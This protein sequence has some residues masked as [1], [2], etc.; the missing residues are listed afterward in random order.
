MRYWL[1][2]LKE[3][4]GRHRFRE[5]LVRAGASTSEI[6]MWLDLQTHATV[7][8]KVRANANAIH[9]KVISS[10]WHFSRC[11]IETIDLC[12]LW[13]PMTALDIYLLSGSPTKLRMPSSVSR[14]VDVVLRATHSAK[15]DVAFRSAQQYLLETMYQSLFLVSRTQVKGFR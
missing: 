5:S 1:T 15:A 7:L 14:D 10:S 8:E 4:L 2:V 12:S 11:K 9:G 13:R 6:D 3:P